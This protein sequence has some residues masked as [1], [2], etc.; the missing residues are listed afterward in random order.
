MHYPEYYQLA[1]L[2][3]FSLSVLLFF[4]WWWCVS[5]F[6]RIVKR[7]LL[8]FYAA[9]AW[10]PIA[11]NVEQGLWVPAIA[12]AVFGGFMEGTNTLLSGI[13]PL[14]V[15]SAVALVL[16]LSEALFIRAKRD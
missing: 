9:C 13:R 16:V 8:L 4:L 11:V 3:Y 10:T 12:V 2:G 1:W 6:N 5:P 7:G 15:T 14:M